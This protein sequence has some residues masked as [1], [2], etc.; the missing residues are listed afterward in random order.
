MLLISM[1]PV[2]CNEGLALRSTLRT[3]NA[4]LSSDLCRRECTDR[5]P[6]L[7]FKLHS[8]E[9]FVCTGSFSIDQDGKNEIAILMRDYT[10]ERS[11]PQ[12]GC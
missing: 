11:R 1:I 12:R 8:S 3:I 4:L 2:E 7:Y 5:E 9:L 10:E 6:A